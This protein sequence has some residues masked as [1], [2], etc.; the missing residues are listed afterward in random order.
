[1]MPTAGLIESSARERHTLAKTGGN[2]SISRILEKEQSTRTSSR[3]AFGMLTT[4]QIS[5]SVY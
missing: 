3:T 5:Q 4:Y 2:D 1:M